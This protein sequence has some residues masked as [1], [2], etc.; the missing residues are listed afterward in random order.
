MARTGLGGTCSPND[1]TSSTP[2]LPSQ[3]V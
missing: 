3:K 2:A 1:I